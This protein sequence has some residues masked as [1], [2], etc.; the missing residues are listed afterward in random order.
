MFG[1]GETGVGPVGPLPVT[2]MTDTTESIPPRNLVG[3]GGINHENN[4]RVTTILDETNDFVHE[5][6][7][8]TCQGDRRKQN[9]IFLTELHNIF[10]VNI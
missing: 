4:D 8:R 10:N 6:N 2:I 9:E 1:G 7:Y 3:G 5:Y